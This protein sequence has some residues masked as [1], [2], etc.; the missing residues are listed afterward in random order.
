MKWEYEGCGKE[1]S[2][3]SRERHSY[4]YHNNCSGTREA[5]ETINE[6]AHEVKDIDLTSLKFLVSQIRISLIAIDQII[7]K[8]D[9]LDKK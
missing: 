4:L 8:C 9:G 6:R 1:F 3:N 5:G 7:Q 2:D